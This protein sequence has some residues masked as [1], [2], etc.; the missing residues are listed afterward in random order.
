MK[1][2][3][4]GQNILYT[5]DMYNKRSFDRLP[6]YFGSNKKSIPHAWYQSIM[7][8]SRRY[9]TYASDK[10]PALSGLASH[11]YRPQAATG[12]NYL[13]GLWENDF[14]RCMLWCNGESPSLASSNQDYAI[15]STIQ[16][17]CR[18]TQY[19]A[20]SFSWAAYDGPIQFRLAVTDVNP[21]SDSDFDSQQ[22]QPF[23]F[24]KEDDARYKH[25]KYLH[26][27]QS[28]KLNPR[29]RHI[30]LVCTTSDPY[31]M[32]DKSSYIIVSGMCLSFQY[33]PDTQVILGTL[34]TPTS[35]IFD[36]TDERLSPA[37]FLAL[38]IG[39]KLVLTRPAK[40][41]YSSVTEEESRASNVVWCLFL[42]AARVD[43][44]HY[45]RM[46]VME[47]HRYGEEDSEWVRKEL[48]LR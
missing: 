27:I 25:Q 46:G 28:A 31:G 17:L 23:Y 18:A 10:L 35:L 37:T 13:A 7:M 3:S 16:V 33:K 14:P 20:P 47:F 48:V 41:Y 6:E 11:F 40:N 24:E 19:R 42:K 30:R 26:R 9:L 15:S 29:L 39:R 36:V 5:V 4:F 1:A 8:Y 38:Q 44:S 32:L 43:S 12:G 22:K 2:E 45:E 21:I 34:E